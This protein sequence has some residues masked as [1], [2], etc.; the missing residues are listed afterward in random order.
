MSNQNRMKTMVVAALVSI[1]FIGACDGSSE[2]LSEPDRQDIAETMGGFVTAF[3]T[4]DAATLKTYWSESCP[5]EEVAQSEAASELLTSLITLGD[6]GSFTV[7]VNA[8][9]LKIEVVDEEHV[10]IPLDQPP[11]AVE[12]NVALDP[13][14]SIPGLG[15]IA[16]DGPLGQPLLVEVPLQLAKEDG[17]WKIESCVLFVNDEDETPAN[18]TPAY[19]D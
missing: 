11:G 14:A 9:T 13:D 4:A 6:Q 1:A 18:E 7:T 3:G 5:A 17:E 2:E 15:S 12:S 16:G 10:T 19:S 8:D